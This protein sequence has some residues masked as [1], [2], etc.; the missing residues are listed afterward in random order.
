MSWRWLYLPVLLTASGMGVASLKAAPACA[1]ILPVHHPGG[2]VPDHPPRG[3][4]C[5]PHGCTHL[6]GKVLPTDSVLGAV[7]V[8]PV[9]P[10]Q[11][12]LCGSVAGLEALEVHVRGQVQPH[13][14]EWSLQSP[15]PLT[16]A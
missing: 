13:C 15:G 6:C 16:T 12:Q 14:G 11:V 8:I 7:R 9:P 4:L 5:Q 3:S 10:M 1:P 2:R